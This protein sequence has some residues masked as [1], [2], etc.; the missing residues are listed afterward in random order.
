MRIEPLSRGA[1]TSDLDELGE[2]LCDAVASGASVTLLAPLTVERARAFWHNV[3]DRAHQRSVTLVARDDRGI[4][5]SVQL[6]PAGMQNQPHRADVAQLLVHRRAR[7]R[8]VARALMDELEKW[9]SLGGFKLLTLDTRRGDAAEQLYH[10]SGWT[11][12][13]VVPGY[14]LDPDG[15]PCDTVF[16]YKELVAEPGFGPRAS[17]RGW[18]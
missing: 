16:F 3:L 9:A 2:L 18:L 6:V 13:G 10:D 7:R 14:A 11:R 12:V 1:S 8:G 17:A 15:N 5:G 4:M